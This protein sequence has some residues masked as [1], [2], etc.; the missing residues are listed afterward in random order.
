MTELSAAQRH[1]RGLDQE[2]KPEPEPEPQPQPRVD[3]ESNTM[4][5]KFGAVCQATP[6]SPPQQAKLPELFL[7]GGPLL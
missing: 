4:P 7:E 6:S 5:T 1:R 3:H 2:P